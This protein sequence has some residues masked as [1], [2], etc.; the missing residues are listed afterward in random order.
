MTGESIYEVYAIRYARQLQRKRSANLLAFDIHDGPMPIDFFVWLIKGA[1]R[2]ILVDTGFDSAEAKSRGRE[3]LIEP[4]E[5]LR[6]FGVDAQSIDHVVLT[7]L[8][9]DHAGTT[10]HFPNAL[11]HLQDRE[12]AYA[13]GRNMLHANQRHAFSVGHVT[14][15]VGHVYQERVRF[16]DGDAQL[17]DGISLHLIGGHTAGLQSVRVRT[18]RGWVVLASDAAHFYANI[19]RRIPFPIVLDVG[20][21]FEGWQVLE[22]LASS[23]DHVVPG[24]DPLVREIYPA[25]AIEGLEAYAL[26]QPPNRSLVREEL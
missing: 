4:A 10:H 3:L 2:T 15:V 23:P 5:A 21:M 22:A 12:M 24:H 6:R 9:Y 25:V 20:A 11:F 8:H 7:H 14:Q 16:H 13:T 18:A 17:A 1:D 19:R 26:H